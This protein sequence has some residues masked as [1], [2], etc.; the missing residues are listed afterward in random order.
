MKQAIVLVHGIGEQR[1]SETA[2]GFAAALAG[3]SSFVRSQ[4]SRLSESVGLRRFFMKPKKDRPPTTDIYEFYWAHHMNQSSWGSVLGWA[5]RLLFT[6]YALPR[7]LRAAHRALIT[8]FLGSILLVA[9]A[10]FPSFSGEGGSW[11]IPHPRIA[12]TTIVF[13]LILY[14]CVSRFVRRFLG[15]AARYLTPSPENIKARNAVR[16]E[17]IELL[18]RLHESKDYVRIIV[19]GH[20]LGSV[21]AYD[22]LRHV[23]EDLRKAKYQEA[24][25]QPAMEELLDSISALEDSVR[26]KT[27]GAK[28][29]AFQHAQHQLWREQRKLGV[30]WL[31]TDFITLGSPLAHAPYMLESDFELFEEKKKQ[32]ELP[33]CPPYSSEDD[34]MFY[35]RKVKIDSGGEGSRYW[36]F[37]VLSHGALFACTRW[38]NLY[39]PYRKFFF[40]DIVGGPVSKVL[41]KGIRDIRVRPSEPGFWAKTLASHTKYWKYPFDV[42]VDPGSQKT[43]SKTKGSKESIKRRAKDRATGTKE[44]FRALQASLRLGLKL[45]K[46]DWPPP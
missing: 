16:R 25:D 7:G 4:P 24:F 3:G 36:T 2:R 44:A 14:F 43:A 22:V 6:D 10:A 18:R 31:V 35:K 11:V 34:P 38:T 37:R 5:G 27:Y 30:P 1:P 40:G 45:S 42:V 26:D 20:S 41:G 15:D 23:W 17:G 28:L 13:G 46:K 33:V 12:V 32:Q 8:L 19:V 21:I 39:F 9:W 29:E